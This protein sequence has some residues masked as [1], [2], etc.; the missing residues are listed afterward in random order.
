MD[1]SKYLTTGELAKL[2]HVT[3]NTLFHYDKIGL[4]S[5]EIVLDNEYRYY[6][7]HQIE[8]LD[9]IIMLKELGMSLKE[10]QTFLSDRTPEKLLELF[11]KEEQILAEK[12]RLLKDRGQWMEEKRK[13]V[14]EY[15]DKTPDDIF[16][17]EKEGRYYLMDTFSDSTESEFAE[18]TAELINFYESRSKSICYEIG[19]IQY[20]KDIRQHIYSNYSN[21]ILLTKHRQRGMSYHFMPAGK[22]LMTYFKGHWKDIG[23]AYEQLLAYADEHQIELAEEFLEVYTVDQLMAESVDDYV[24]EISVRICGENLP[25]A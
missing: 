22:Y 23:V 17:R 1:K 21:V 9:A 5:P 25:L 15:L 19:Y 16:V 11:E 2:M 12:I 4:F 8:V 13:N 7:I 18:R 20:A 6:S 10:I 24:T 3:K 14:N